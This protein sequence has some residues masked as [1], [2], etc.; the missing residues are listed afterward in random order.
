MSASAVPQCGVLGYART[1]CF[2]LYFQI[3]L[4]N[5][6]CCFL[7]TGPKLSSR[8]ASFF[9]FFFFFFKLVL[10]WRC[11]FFRLQGP[12]VRATV[13]G[14]GSAQTLWV[15]LDVGAVLHAVQGLCWLP[16]QRHRL[17]AAPLRHRRWHV[18]WS[19]HSQ[20]DSSR[21]RDSGQSVIRLRYLEK[22]P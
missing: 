2:V 14:R 17:R 1:T 7:R 10:P 3:K 18:T 8:F 12:P 21:S 11:C 4:W 9:L 15:W 13:W 20:S 5:K 6:R 19:P 22:L 16:L